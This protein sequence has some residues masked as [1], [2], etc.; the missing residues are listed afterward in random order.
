MRGIKDGHVSRP[1]ADADVGIHGE[2]MCV[3]KVFVEAVAGGP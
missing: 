2:E 3:R 1:L